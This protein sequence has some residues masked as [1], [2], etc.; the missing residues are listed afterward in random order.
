MRLLFIL[1]LFNASTLLGQHSISGKIMDSDNQPIAYATISAYPVS[2]TIQIYSSISNEKGMFFI[3][4]LQS[5]DYKLIIQMLGFKDVELEVLLNKDK[6]L[7]DVILQQDVTELQ[8]VEIIADYSTLENKLGKKVLR[9]GRDLSNTGSTALEAMERIPSVTITQEGGLQ[10]RGSSNVIVYIDGKETARDARTLKHLPAE[11]LEKIEVVTNPSAQYDAEGVAGIVNLVYRKNKKKPFKIGVL[12]NVSAPQR[13]LGG[14]NASYNT[15]SFSFYS[16]ASLSY[17]KSKDL[18]NS[19][20]KNDI[21]DLKFYRNNL[22]YEGVGK[23]RNLDAGITYQ[24]DSTLAVDFEL[25]YN[26][27]NDGYAIVQE[28]FFEYRNTL[29]SSSFTTWSSRR[30]LEDEAIISLG[31]NKSFGK[32]TELKALLSVSGEDEN[33]DSSY[34]DLDSDI[35]AGIA[36]QFLKSSIETESQRL[37]QGKLDYETPFFNFGILQTGF[38]IDLIRYAIVQKVAFQSNAVVLADNDFKVDQEKYAAY[39]L[40]K[41]EFNRFEYEA[42]FRLEHFYSNGLQQSN[43]DR[44]VQKTSK[45]FPSLQLFYKINEHQQ[46]VGFSYS[47]RINR[48]GFFDINPYVSFIDPINLETGNPDLRPELASQF[49]LNYHLKLGKFTSD[50][51]GFY[52]RTTD[53]IQ[54]IIV[55]LNDNQTRQTVANF[56][57]RSDRGI[58]ALIEYNPRGV[59]KTYATFTLNHSVFNDDINTTIFNR[60]TVWGARLDQQLRFRNNWTTNFSQHYRAP[61][62]GPQSKTASQFFVNFS[63]SKKFNN[64]KGSISLNASDV[65]N[66]REFETT[67]KGADFSVDKSYKWQT[68]RITL[69]LQ[70]T[71]ME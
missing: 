18:E 71:L 19:E 39:V 30:E 54:S 29:E 31:M 28:N 68:R 8:E 37:F 1:F 60:I 67:V 57:V 63:L 7:R 52:R 33:N 3:A 43:N 58:E 64:G 13:V 14:F 38:K 15:S 42:G 6:V 12:A 16:N 35:P 56:D 10:I 32:E 26:R 34:D 21:G 20:R 66:Q 50:L 40:H 11:V 9:I 53:V 36:Q 46:T 51:T 49:E 5:A 45:L 48:P 61:R 17:G 23:Q 24:P 22:A 47:R 69:G 25:N 59:F 62:F 4:G 41:K 55:P 70:Y 2:D 27:W 65:F 44:S